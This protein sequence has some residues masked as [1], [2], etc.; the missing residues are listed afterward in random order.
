MDE[1]G[2][3]T[4]DSIAY[5]YPDYKTALRGRFEAG[6]LVE[7]QEAEITGVQGIPLPCAWAR[8]H[9]PHPTDAGHLLVLCEGVVDVDLEAATWD[10]HVPPERFP[11]GADMDYLQ[12]QDFVVSKD[13][14]HTVVA[15]YTADFS[16]VELWEVDKDGPATLLAGG[17]QSAERSLEGP[18]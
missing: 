11:D 18:Y 8:E 2:E 9:R 7:A 5:I 4:G 17:L 15:I 6:V 14:L 16:E 1:R 12:P 10:W 13:G 3:L